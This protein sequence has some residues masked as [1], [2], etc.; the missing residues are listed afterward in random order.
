MVTPTDLAP[1]AD[2]ELEAITPDGSGEEDVPDPEPVVADDIEKD[3]APAPDGTPD[4]LDDVRQRLDEQAQNLEKLTADNQRLRSELGRTQQ[5]ERRFEE[6]SGQNPLAAVDPRL[7][8]LEDR[9][10]SMLDNQIAAEPDEA[11]RTVLLRD[12]SELDQQRADRRTDARVD[13]HLARSAPDTQA[14]EVDS[15]ST[16]ARSGV[17]GYARGKGVDPTAIPQ[18]AWIQLPGESFTDSAKRVEGVID[19]LASENGATERTGERRR[20]AAGG[21]PQKSGTALAGDDL[22][23]ESLTPEG[24]RR[25]HDDQDYHD[26]VD[27]AVT[28]LKG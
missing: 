16:A 6:F 24:E 7:D 2:A 22:I 10:L 15:D 26:R 13:T 19:G 9:Q 23:N 21:A 28:A 14:P 25:Y 5:L 18:S 11:R 8:A 3:D 12:R 27:K 4:P 1:A 20:A 17:E